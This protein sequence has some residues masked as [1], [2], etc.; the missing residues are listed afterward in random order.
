ML[1]GETTML[2][3]LLGAAAAAFQPAPCAL[4]GVAETFEREQQVECGWVSVPRENGGGK[5][6]RLWTARIRAT[7][8]SPAPDPILYING[9]PGVA[10]VD[11]ILPNLATNE[12]IRLLRKDRDV[13]LF[14]QRGSGHSEEAMCPGLGES[15]AA[16]AAAGL[17]PAAEQER[18]R[19]AFAACAAELR[20]AGIDLGAYTTD[21]T[22]RDI[23][24]LRA[25][26][27]ARQWNLWSISYGSLVAMHAM[28][29]HPRTIRSAILNSPYPPNSVTWAEQAVSTAEAYQAIDRSCSRQPA[30]LERFGALMPKLEAT[31][32]R[33]EREPIRDGSKIV[34]GRQFADALWPLAVRSATVRFVP[35]AIHRAHAGDTGLIRKMVATFAG[36]G[37]F[38]GFAPA[39]AQAISCHEGGRTRIF[40]SRARAL[41]PGLA[42][43]RPDDSWDRL[44]E[45]FRPGFAAPEF[46]APVASD[47]PILLYAGLLDPATP[48]VDAMHAMRFLAKATL[49]QVPDAAHD[50]LGIDACTRG[51]AAAFLRRPER[52]PDL[53]CIATREERPFAT[54]GLDELLAPAKK[55]Q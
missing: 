43:D 20:R 27:G 44:C 45:S 39:Q 21:S 9:G 31:L 22:V 6:I 16:V 28:R 33:L 54:E 19:A 30:C 29:T 11:S 37:S 3:T 40:H 46:F 36:G 25:A 38:G 13:I 7:G 34:N 5:R 17:T 41:Y 26:L 48:P 50:P 15:L 42:P 14:D 35:L 32:A 2:L 55:A 4:P 12:S 51:I 8:K 49:V 1:Q 47:I 18:G 53:S 52:A 24:A 23:E 10:T